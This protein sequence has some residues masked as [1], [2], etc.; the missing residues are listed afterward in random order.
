VNGDAVNHCAIK[1]K[2]SHCDVA[3]VNHP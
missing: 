3:Q 1:G 2:D